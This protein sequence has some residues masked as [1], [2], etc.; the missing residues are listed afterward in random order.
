[1]YINI[2]QGFEAS[3]RNLFKGIEKINKALTSV[4][5][6]NKNWDN[7]KI[8]APTGFKRVTPPPTYDDDTASTKKSKGD[9]GSTGTSWKAAASNLI[10]RKNNDG[11]KRGNSVSIKDAVVGKVTGFRHVTHVGVDDQNGIVIRDA[12]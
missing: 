1:M 12:G 5:E 2:L 7:V 10:T 4:E 9:S 6:D 3:K 8:G 11:T